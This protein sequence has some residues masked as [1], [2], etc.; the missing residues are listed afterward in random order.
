MKKSVEKQALQKGR[1]KN[2][3]SGLIARL[4]RRRPASEPGFTELELK[5]AL[6]EEGCPVCRLTISCERDYFFAFLH[7]G[8]T[9]LEVIDKLTASLGFCNAHGHYLVHHTN[10]L[11]Q[12][13]FVQQI[14]S[15]RLYEALQP[16]DRR[17][18]PP[19]LSSGDPARLCPACLS[20]SESAGRAVFFLAKLLKDA[21]VRRQYGNPGLLCLAHLQQITPRLADDVL[22]QLLAIHGQRLASVLAIVGNRG[23]VKIDA[24]GHADALHATVGHDDGLGAFLPP[25]SDG[26]QSVPVESVGRL[27]KDF[28]HRDACP[29]CLA[30]G[31]AWRTWEGWFE[32]TGGR[33]DKIEDLLPRCPRHVWAVL[34]TAGPQLSQRILQNVLQLAGMQVSFALGKLRQAPPKILFRDPQSA[35]SRLLRPSDGSVRLARQSLVRGPNCPVCRRLDLA[36]ERTLRLLFRMLVLQHHQA[37]YAAGHGLCLKHFAVALAMQPEARLKDFLCRIQAA[38]LGLLEWELSEYLRKSAWQARPDPP[39]DEQYAPRR[40]IVRFSGWLG[41]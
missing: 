18:L 9:L 10:G 33:E 27:E 25:A 15:R 26:T 29:V 38:K 17:P 5:R 7:E 11:H 3:V 30:V 21:H 12:A 24:A 4:R 22:A 35:I 23:P 1:T 16:A 39:G 41:D 13:A 37:Q 14:I 19:G 36:V 8:Y 28:Q 20:R 32:S 31:R 6:K 40:A 34:E 2:R